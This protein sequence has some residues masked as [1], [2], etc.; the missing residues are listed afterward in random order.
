MRGPLDS[1][2]GWLE[3]NNATVMAMLILVIGAVLVGK[4]VGGL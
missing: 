3:H 2:K 4:G 1:L